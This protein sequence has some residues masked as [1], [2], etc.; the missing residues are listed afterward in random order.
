MDH[1]QAMPRQGP[2][3]EPVAFAWRYKINNLSKITLTQTNEYYIF[4]EK[5]KRRGADAKGQ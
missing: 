4:C 1:L 5:K 3:A 2:V